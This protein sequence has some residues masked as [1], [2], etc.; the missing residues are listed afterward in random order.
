M[1]PF[2]RFMRN[3]RLEKGLLLKDL[4]DQLGVTP[5]YL[6]SLEHGKKGLPNER[7]IEQIT[8]VLSLDTNQQRALKEAVWNSATSFTISSKATPFAFETANAFARK[9]PSLSEIKLRKIKDIL[10]E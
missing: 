7:I 9:L 1:T 8:K 2:G 3:F 6:S 4:A 10:D 5:S